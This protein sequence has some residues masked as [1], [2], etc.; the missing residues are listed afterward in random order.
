MIASVRQCRE[1]AP[2]RCT[3]GRNCVSV[4]E[5]Y[6][7]WSKAAAAWLVE[8]GSALKARRATFGGLLV[9]DGL[10]KSRGGGGDEGEDEDDEAVNARVLVPSGGL[11]PLEYV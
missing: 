9:R 11:P 3:T 4:R 8:G 6:D 2:F 5:V 7:E 1:L 10:S